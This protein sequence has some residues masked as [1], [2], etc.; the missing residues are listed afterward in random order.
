MK[1]NDQFLG[2]VFISAGGPMFRISVDGAIYEFE[3]H[4]YCGPTLLNRRGEPLQN[5]PSNFLLAASL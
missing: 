4:P 2:A 1:I 3:I 5:Q